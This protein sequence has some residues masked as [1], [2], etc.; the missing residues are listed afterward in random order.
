[1]NCFLEKLQSKNFRNL[2][3]DLFHFGSKI[4]CI[5]GENGNGKTN[6]LELIHFITNNKSFR[7]NAKFNQILNTGSEDGQIQVQVTFNKNEEII[8]ISGKIF[9]HQQ[10]WYQNNTELK[11]IKLINSIFINPF[12]SNQFHT[13][14][15]FRRAMFDNLIGILFPEYK[16][17]I[18]QYEN[19]LRSRNKILSSPKVEI[20]YLNAYQEKFESLNYQITFFRREFIAQLNEFISE[21]FNKI[22]SEKHLLEIKLSSKLVDLTHDQVANLIRSNREKEITRRITYYGVHRDDY[23]FHFDGFNSYEYCS[24]GQQKMA[25]LSLLFAYIELFRYKFNFYPIVLIDDVSGELDSVR[26]SK[27]IQY[28][29]NCKFQTFITTANEAFRTELEKINSAKKIYINDGNSY[30]K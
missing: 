1:M 11:K 9:E 19:I 21:T 3:N 29:E 13:S 18:K 4:N 8:F 23:V 27:L 15:T 20:E 5:F 7:K 22:F 26:W 12:D 25:Y 28:L 24:L 17:I 30:I 10:Y 2:S 16:K 14:G 6:I